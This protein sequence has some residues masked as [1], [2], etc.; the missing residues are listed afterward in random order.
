M[1]NKYYKKIVRIG[2]NSQGVILPIAWTRYNGLRVGDHVAV[3]SNDEILIRLLPKNT[4]IIG[5]ELKKKT[6]RDNR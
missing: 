1:S 6:R 2:E 4:E 3:I 5:G